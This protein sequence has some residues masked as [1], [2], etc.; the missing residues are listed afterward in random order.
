MLSLGNVLI[1]IS[2]NDR[3]CKVLGLDSSLKQ[4]IELV[5]GPVLEL[6][7]PAQDY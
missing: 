5:V 6:W 2:L 4:D 1:C 7:E 3:R